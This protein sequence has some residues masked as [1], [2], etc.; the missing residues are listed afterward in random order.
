[1]ASVDFEFLLSAGEREGI[2]S[3]MLT[4]HIWIREMID[5]AGGQIRAEER[6]TQGGTRSWGNKFCNVRIGHL[7]HLAR[8]PHDDD[9][10]P[11]ARVSLKLQA[12][13]RNESWTRRRTLSI[14]ESWTNFGILQL[15]QRHVVSRSDCTSGDYACV[16]GTL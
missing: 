14:S 1:M 10:L 16:S 6:R 4:L 2:R 11:R 9:S 12:K 8:R 3:L 5:G 15:S 7:V 13:D